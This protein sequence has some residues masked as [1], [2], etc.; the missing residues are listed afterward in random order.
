MESTVD[1]LDP[2]LWP[3]VLAA[4]RAAG[5]WDCWTTE[6]VGRHGRPGRVVTALCAAE[7]RPA[8]ADALFRHT[9][10]LGVRWSAHR[11][12]MLPRQSAVVAVGPPGAEQ[13]VTVKVADGPGGALTVQPELAEA[14]AAAAA[15]GWPVRAVCEAAAVRY[16]GDLAVPRPAT[17]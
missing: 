13:Q 3:S 17:G 9:T 15:L 2:R 12:L 11:R 1:D 8:V 10:T 7:V 14:E 16:R 6:T 4:L 5:A